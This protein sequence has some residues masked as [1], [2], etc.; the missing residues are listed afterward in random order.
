MICKSKLQ[1]YCA[2][3]CGKYVESI[4]IR[5]KIPRLQCKLYTLSDLAAVLSFLAAS[6]ILMEFEVQNSA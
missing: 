6:E 3:I 5:L 4:G 2:K 1:F